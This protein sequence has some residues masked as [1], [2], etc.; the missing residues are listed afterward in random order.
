M[1]VDGKTTAISDLVM[2]ENEFQ[3]PSVDHSGAVRQRKG[4]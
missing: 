2:F 4:P 1:P 3:V